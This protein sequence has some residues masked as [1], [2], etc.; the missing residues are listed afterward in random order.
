MASYRHWGFA[1]LVLMV[2][3]ALYLMGT[4]APLKP[5]TA[6]I[7]V[8][9]EPSPTPPT[10]TTSLPHQVGQTQIKAGALS[11]FKTQPLYFE[12]NVGQA[13]ER[14][15][16]LAR[17]L[18]YSMFLTGTEAVMV[19]G[20]EQSVVRIQLVGC[21]KNPEPEGLKEQ[22]GHS[23]YFLGNDSSKWRLNVSHFAKAMFKDVYPG[24]DLVYYGNRGRLE[25]DF[26]LAPG[27]DPSRIQLGFDGANRIETNSAGDLKVQTGSGSLVQEAPRVYQVKNGVRKTIPCAYRVVGEDRVTLSLESYDLSESLVID[28]VLEF[29]SY[30]G[31]THS[32]I[33]YG[34]DV[35]ASGNCY[36]AGETS[37]LDFP[38]A[39]A[40]QASIAGQRDVF[41]TKFNSSAS[42]LIYSTYIG[43]SSNDV[44]S[45]IVVDPTG[46]AYVTGSVGSADFPTSNA[47]QG[48]MPGSGNA[49]VLKLN[50]TGNSLLFSTYFGG[51]GGEYGKDIAIDGSGNVYIVGRTTSNDLPTLNAYQSARSGSANGFFSKLN[52]SGNALIYSS[53]LGGNN[54]NG[55]DQAFSVAVD[56]SQNLYIA[57]ETG[58]TD[59]PTFG[60]FQGSNGGQQD[61]FVCKFDSSGSNL[62]FATYMG[63]TKVDHPTSMVVDGSSN[64]FIAGAA[65]SNSIN[66]PLVGAQLGNVSDSSFA[67]K[68][69][70]AGALVFSSR[71]G[72]G[73]PVALDGNGNF[74]AGLRKISPTLD[75][76]IYNFSIP[77]AG[78]HDTAVTA[79]GVVYA[80][81]GN[82]IPPGLATPGAFQQAPA[83]GSWNDS[84]VAKIVPAPFATS[85]NLITHFEVPI[86]IVLSATDDERDSITYSVMSP[87]QN[88]ELSGVPPNLTYTP[89]NGF[90]GNDSF[91]F[92]G[93]DGTFDGNTATA[94]ISVTNTAPGVTGS[95]SPIAINLGDAVAF[96]A[97]GNDPDGDA[98][99][100]SWNFGDGTTSLEQNPAHIYASVGTYDAIVTVTDIASAT[101]TSTVTIVVGNAPTA[102]FTTSDVVGFVNNPLAFDATFSS[103]PE[104][105]IVSYTWDFGDGSPLGAGQLISRTYTATGSYNVTLTIVDAEGLID[106]TSR[107]IEVLPEDQLGLFNADIDFMVRWDR[108][109]ENRDKF[110][111]NALVNVGDTQIQKGTQVAL[112]IADLRFEGSLD[113]KLRDKTD[114]NEKWIVKAGLRKQSFGE[115]FL[116]LRVKRATLGLNFNQAGAVAG[117]GNEVLMDMPMRIEIAGR[118][119]EVVMDS[120][121]TFKKGGT[122]AK[123]S[124]EGP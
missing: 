83:P 7:A 110:I 99:T 41:I 24:I 100:Y 29:F 108:N 82:A 120:E 114:G 46:N 54:F 18:G 101:A 59:F 109:R 96:S 112:E 30:L 33:A 71:L 56:G 10:V 39:E 48:T 87:P 21:S 1:A 9:P 44:P 50:S 124:G 27:A 93:N 80:T 14:V 6:T 20:Q 86:G 119:F 66:F 58:S 3:V 107:T 77:G 64:I 16:F 31:G 75:A 95:G 43:G 4:P 123:G 65:E 19:L 37:S 72:G 51:T 81:G 74:Y 61:G 28:P 122:K 42:S 111:L 23:N 12:P 49:F 104:N 26:I 70:S 91:T 67:A 17:G 117:A 121:F 25:F 22:E 45:S 53:Y 88:G 94:S 79:L 62:L 40:L 35:D 98:L 78:V 69:S 2:G 47:Y 8:T 90:I 68:I 106:S 52:S 73:G 63:G 92:K 11:V 60:A 13:D 97:N 38:T 102:R 57:G 15:K 55:G 32:D 115:V 34:I 5:A 113:G 105:A 85:Q 116:K 76:I 36:V 103:D 84:F 118:S 89:N